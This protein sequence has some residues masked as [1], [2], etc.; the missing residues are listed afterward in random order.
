MS[1][2]P[3]PILSRMEAFS[4]RVTQF[5][6]LA[7]AAPDL[8]VTLG[9]F[10]RIE[11]ASLVAGLLLE[12]D[13]RPAIPRIEALVHA[14]VVGCNGSRS[15]RRDDI[16][17][18]FNRHVDRSDLRRSEDPAEDLF[19]MRVWS[20]AGNF[21][22]LGGIWEAPDYI[23]QCV[24]DLIGTFPD[25][26]EFRVIE[27]A[28]TG[29]L[30]IADDAV[31]RA[32]LSDL[33]TGDPGYATQ[34]PLPDGDTMAADASF[35]RFSADDLAAL[36]VEPAMLAAFVLPPANYRDLMD[37]DTRFSTL[38]RF[39]VLEQKGEYLLALP[40]AVSF[41]IR[42]FFVEAMFRLGL[43]GHFGDELRLRQL[44]G[45]AYECL[46]PM[47]GEQVVL[48]DRPPINLELPVDDMVCRFDVGSYCIAWF[49][50][51]RRFR[52]GRAA[53]ANRPY[54]ELLPQIEKQMVEL[55]D[56]VNRQPDFRRGLVLVVYG[57]FTGGFRMAVPKLPPAW[58]LQSYSLP[59][60]EIMARTRGADLARLWRLSRAE[61][62]LRQRGVSIANMNGDF[63][64]YAWW[65]QNLHRLLPR[66]VAWKGRFM[67]QIPMNGLLDLRVADRRAH[68]RHV[69]FRPG[70][71]RA[72][73][74]RRK[75]PDAL[76]SDERDQ[77]FFVEARGSRYRRLWAVIETTKRGWWVTTNQWSEDME[78][79]SIILQVWK[80]ACEWTRRLA[81][82]LEAELSMLAGPLECQ[83]IFAEVERWH[84][85]KSAPLLVEAVKPPTFTVDPARATGVITLDR[86]FFNGYRQ[87]T[88]RAERVLAHTLAK[89]A[90][91]M[92]GRP[93]LDEVWS[94]LEAAVFPNDDARFFHSHLTDDMEFA[95][96]AVNGPRRPLLEE[97]ILIDARA[98]S[99]E[100][101]QQIRVINN[102]EEAKRVIFAAVDRLKRLNM[103]QLAE[104][105]RESVVARCIGSLEEVRADSHQWR[106]TAASLRALHDP[107]ELALIAG[108]RESR[109]AAQAIASR[110][111]IEATLFACPDSGGG[112][113]AEM[114]FED[115]VGRQLA[116]M[117]LAIFAEEL[118]SPLEVEPVRVLP[119][120][121][122]EC[123]GVVSDRILRDF[124]HAVF[125]ERFDWAADSYADFFIK[126]SGPRNDALSDQLNAG[127][128][129]E[130]GLDTHDIADSIAFLAAAAEKNHQSFWTTSETDLTAQLA[131]MLGRDAATVQTFLRRI[132]LY[133][134]ALTDGDAP[135]GFKPRDTA[136]WHYRRRFSL[137]ARPLV[138]LDR[139]ENPRLLVCPAQWCESFDYL[140]RQTLAGSFHHE[141]FDTAAMRDVVR[142][143]ARQRSTQF[144]KKVGDAFE[145][146]GYTVRLNLAMSTLGAPKRLG[147]IDVVAIKPSGELWIIE[148]K[149]L[150]SAYSAADVVHQLAEF[151]G[152]PGDDLGQHLD[153]VAWLTANR[154]A[155]E[156][157][158]GNQS[159][160]PPH[161]LLVTS[162]LVPLQFLTDARFKGTFVVNFG[163]L[164]AKI[165]GSK[166]EE[167]GV[168]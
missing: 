70:L 59:N 161:A 118:K 102:R 3:E 33:E 22:F 30:K 116:L 74:V 149:L 55:V 58:Y 20:D 151:G 23:V 88:N 7:A 77:P 12:P 13:C 38:N 125:Q 96:V 56:F 100:P 106:L 5:A 128:V 42:E 25:R 139:A 39:P 76:F 69:A 68:D 127:F 107:A 147:E 136:P 75:T 35:L 52:A 137:L 37:E 141:F 49:A 24:L 111:L 65:L 64:L 113:I 150:R 126:Q 1:G 166:T 14:I 120:G 51:D 6:H 53:E 168:N 144:E 108:Q 79:R 44:D 103:A 145:R 31:H 148:C 72:I 123:G 60:L 160:R 50:R 47:G 162:N 105:S 132:R 19:V 156:R 86:E 154:S 54:E 15:P 140:L 93:L 2:I 21:R 129:A 83:L 101:S 40:T 81:P 26:P 99:A 157:H 119:S 155:L 63:N 34:V 91:G 73:L 80:S 11:A 18:W 89:V 110:S 17:R 95:G 138:A 97:E 112:E 152:N 165:L 104:L 8:L 114:E 61:A 98:G 48:E 45:L 36:G 163:A 117:E 27:R 124:S 134:W 82:R 135:V 131:G 29:L 146:A 10:D 167:D 41:A 115:L 122:I 87:P 66:D 16:V 109:R 84:D 32:E 46:A 85:A 92:A 133:P 130:Y 4:T 67:F 159:L 28:I 78:A 121:E 43:G 164:G 62:D 142:D 9:A 153:R 90:F 143:R 158:L 94:K 57:G 71:N